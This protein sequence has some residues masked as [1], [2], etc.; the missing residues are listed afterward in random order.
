MTQNEIKLFKQGIL[1]MALYDR[2]N[3]DV[4]MGPGSASFVD[5]VSQECHIPLTR[6]ERSYF[7]SWLDQKMRQHEN[8]TFSAPPAGF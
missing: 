5:R 3:P 7:I 8:G 2:A 1:G 6:L 4:G